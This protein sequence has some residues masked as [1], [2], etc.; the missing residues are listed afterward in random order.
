MAIPSARLK[1]PQGACPAA[2]GGT[3]DTGAGCTT[4]GH[5][6]RATDQ[7]HQQRRQGQ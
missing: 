5:A 4:H 2:T 1:G 6:M 3:A 7:A